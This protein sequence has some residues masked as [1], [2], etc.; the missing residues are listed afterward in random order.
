[1]VGWFRIR[2]KK[3]LEKE[4]LVQNLPGQESIYG[5]KKGKKMIVNWMILK[6]IGSILILSLI[7]WIVVKILK[8]RKA[9]IPEVRKKYWRVKDRIYWEIETIEEALMEKVIKVLVRWHPL[10]YG[11]RS[12]IS[13]LIESE[14]GKLEEAVQEIF[15]ERGQNKAYFKVD[16]EA[17]RRYYDVKL[18]ELSVGIR[19]EL[20][21]KY[22]YREEALEYIIKAAARNTLEEIK[23][24]V[25]R[26]VCTFIEEEEEENQR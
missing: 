25:K 4:Y 3:K 21:I 19:K 6:I 26:P 11:E 18:L 7:V 23:E 16:K 5:R 2:D 17:L 8:G 10:V 22:M 1:M 9:W 15:E 14:K 13:G 12:L 24:A 20:G